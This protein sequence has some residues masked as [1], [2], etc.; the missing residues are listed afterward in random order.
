MPRGEFNKIVQA[1]KNHKDTVNKVGDNIFTK[2]FMQEAFEDAL[3]DA[4]DQAKPFLTQ[5]EQ[6]VIEKN[7]KKAII[8][9]R[10]GYIS[11]Q[12]CPKFI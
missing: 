9:A 7:S 6:A 4:I 10:K 5:K 2:N 3:K 1:L 11:G 12:C 8:D